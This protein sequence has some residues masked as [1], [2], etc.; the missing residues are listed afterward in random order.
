MLHVQNEASNPTEGLQIELELRDSHLFFDVGQLIIIRLKGLYLGQSNDVIKIGGVFTS[1]GNRSVGRLPKNVVFDHILTACTSSVDIR[2]LPMSIPELN[3]S[4]LNT[5]VSIDNVEFNE[6]LLDQT[7]AIEEEET[8]RILIDC[9]DN[10]LIMLNSG[11]SDFQSEIIPDNK[12]TAIGVV[13]K[14]K[15]KY[16]LIIRD[17][18]DLEFNSERCEEVVDEFTSDAILLTELADPNNNSG[19]RFVELYNASDEN[20]SLKGWS[21]VRYT[22]D[23]ADI[24]STINLSEYTI[25]SNELLVIS[26][27]ESEFETVYGFTPNMAVGTNSPADSNGDDTI[28]LIDPFGAIIDIFGV[29]GVD[30][31]GTNHEFEDGRAVRNMDIVKGNMNYTASEWK[32]YNDT[33]ANGTINQPQNAPAD[34]TPGIR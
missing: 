8:E 10:E 30:G 34:F 12:G 3:D 17:T 24:S 15:G 31:S 26:P 22:N 28:A 5:L 18:A 14:D 16:Q 21:L 25:E 7:F 29:I 4:A 13:T 1:F 20:L 9:N 19:A 23:N 27:N 33:G 2:P 11:Y 32:V 6:D